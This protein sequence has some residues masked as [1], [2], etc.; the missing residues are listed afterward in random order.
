[1]SREEEIGKVAAQLDDLL[2]DLAA[3]VDALNAILTHPEPPD[4][5]E[6]DERMVA[7]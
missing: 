6:R 3:S 1:M 4:N 7:P 5:G 2:D